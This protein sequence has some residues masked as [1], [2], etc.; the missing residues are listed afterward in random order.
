MTEVRV[1]VRCFHLPMILHLNFLLIVQHCFLQACPAVLPSFALKSEWVF[2]IIMFL[3]R[4]ECKHWNASQFWPLR[5]PRYPWLWSMVSAML[6][7]LL[8]VWHSLFAWLNE[9]DL[10]LSLSL[11]CLLMENCYHRFLWRCYK[12]TSPLKCSSRQPN[13]NCL[14]NWGNSREFNP[15]CLTAP[16]SLVP[17]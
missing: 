14:Q 12:G 16:F 3:H 6:L 4:F 15:Y 13:G 5:T 17:K 10:E 7:L 9:N 8:L 2:H 11:Q 1:W